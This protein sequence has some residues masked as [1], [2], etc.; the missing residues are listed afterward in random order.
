MGSNGLKRTSCGGDT[1]LLNLLLEV[2]TG[3]PS[4]LLLFISLEKYIIR[5]QKSVFST[6]K[7]REKK[8]PHQNS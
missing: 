8:N 6:G 2:Y 3:N 1:A 5:K 7:E 4:L